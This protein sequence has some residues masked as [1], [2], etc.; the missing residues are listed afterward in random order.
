MTDRPKPATPRPAEAA[1]NH[2]D[3]AR[4]GHKHHHHEPTEPLDV[5]DGIPDRAAR[6]PA[7]RYAAIIV[8]FALW[9][10]ALVYIQIAGGAH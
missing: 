5:V 6:R 9:L 8:V 3:H 1:A 7:W 4:H 10:A 2:A